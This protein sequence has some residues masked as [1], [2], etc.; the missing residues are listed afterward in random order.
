MSREAISPY[1]LTCADT[2]VISVQSIFSKGYSKIQGI[3]MTSTQR[4]I[5]STVV[6]FYAK[7]YLEFQS[8]KTNVGLRSYYFYSIFA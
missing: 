2:L 5:R 4:Y 3:M 8:T 7:S 6:Y 1:I